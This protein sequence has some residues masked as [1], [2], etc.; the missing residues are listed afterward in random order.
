MTLINSPSDMQVDIKRLRDMY[1]QDP[2]AKLV[3]DHLGTFL[4]NRTVTTIDRLHSAIN[5][6]DH[7]VSRPD[8]IRFLRNLE[9]LGC[10]SRSEERRVGKECRL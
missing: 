5:S 7:E 4:R 1:E 3:F 9:E 2:V 10:G 6:P 8:V